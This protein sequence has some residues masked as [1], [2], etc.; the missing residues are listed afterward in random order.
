MDF[1]CP[2]PRLPHDTPNGSLIHC[3]TARDCQYN[4]MRVTLTRT[5]NLDVTMA[6]SQVRTLPTPSI[7]VS[8][9]PS[10][11][12]L[13]SDVNSRLRSRLALDTYS[14]PVNQNGSFE[15]DRVVKSGYLQKRTQKTKV[16]PITGA[17]P[18]RT[19]STDL[20]PRPGS[21]FTSF[22]ARPLFPSTDPTRRTSSGTSCTWR[23]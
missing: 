23:T 20:L 4:Y 14:S 16:C 11:I 8:I 5:N 6:Q 3:V 10:T 19:P 22:F 17:E 7:D 13:P 1:D 9:P 18:S 15:F 12:T 21:P 2:S